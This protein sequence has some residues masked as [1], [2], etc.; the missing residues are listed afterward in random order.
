MK[1]K[2]EKKDYAFLAW[3][4]FIV[5]SIGVIPTAIVAGAWYHYRDKIKK[6]ITKWAVQGKFDELKN[7]FKYIFKG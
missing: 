2:L 7:K 3:A 5:Y 4:G 6:T 1:F